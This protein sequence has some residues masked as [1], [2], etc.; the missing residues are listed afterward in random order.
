[1]SPRRRRIVDIAVILVGVGCLVTLAWILYD[2]V[3]GSY[4]SPSGATPVATT[5]EAPIIIDMGAPFIVEKT[6]PLFVVTTFWD[7]LYVYRTELD[8]S[9]TQKTA[10]TQMAATAETRTEWQIVLALAPPESAEAEKARRGLAE[11][12]E[13]K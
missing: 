12:L 11:L 4:C 5:E 2:C 9:L 6:V 3:F 8:E 13:K 7:W 1:M 10:L